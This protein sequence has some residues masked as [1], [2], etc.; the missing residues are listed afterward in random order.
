MVQ[1]LILLISDT[2][3]FIIVDIYLLLKCYEYSVRTEL[4]KRVYTIKVITT[5]S[6]V[7]KG[8]NSNTAIT[9]YKS[10]SP[11]YDI[12]TISAVTRTFTVARSPGKISDAV[13]DM[14]NDHIVVACELS[15]VNIRDVY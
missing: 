13:F 15:V 4:I 12:H 9:L 7:D 6:Y 2:I 10:C 3:S 1:G 14:R 8:N 5:V 11:L